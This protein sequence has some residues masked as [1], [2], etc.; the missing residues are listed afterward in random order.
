MTFKGASIFS[1]YNLLFSECTH[2]NEL[3]VQKLQFLLKINI[4]TNA[5]ILSIFIL[6]I[7]ISYSSAAAT[8]TWLQKLIACKET[9]YNTVTTA[10]YVTI[11]F[12][13]N[14]LFLCM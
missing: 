13:E 5:L 2:A 1:T 9:F 14:A 3:K 11:S 12:D 8:A 6:F 4:N 7:T 10:A